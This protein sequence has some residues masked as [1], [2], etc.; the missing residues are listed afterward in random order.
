MGQLPYGLICNSK[1]RTG[2]GG[3][4]ERDLVTAAALLYDHARE[5]YVDDKIAPG[6]VLPHLF[7]R[8]LDGRDGGFL[9]YLLPF[10]LEGDR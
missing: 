6:R 9:P 5:N 4:A 8:H 10:I 3:G 7:Q 2:L 1:L